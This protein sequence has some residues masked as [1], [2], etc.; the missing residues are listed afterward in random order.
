M[1]WI[2]RSKATSIMYDHRP[3]H[4][5]IIK[6]TRFLLQPVIAACSNSRLNAPKHDIIVHFP[7][8]FNNQF[9]SCMS[10]L[11]EENQKRSDLLKPICSEAGALIIM[12]H[13]TVVETNR[14]RVIHDGVLLQ[15]RRYRYPFS[16]ILSSHIFSD[17]CC[18]SSWS[19]R[20]LDVLGKSCHGT[21]ETPTR[22]LQF[23]GSY[24]KNGFVLDPHF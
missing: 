14:G 5:L 4:P 20:F 13:C 3:L 19:R 10:L 1:P 18:R 7:C 8:R 6:K 2:E 15:V 23:L 24:R 17:L 16:R 12:G 9:V 22:F 21:A 11:V